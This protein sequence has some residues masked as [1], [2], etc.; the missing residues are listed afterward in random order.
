MPWTQLEK[1]IQRSSLK[2]FEVFSS[3]KVGVRFYDTE[4]FTFEFREW[5]ILLNCFLLIVT[6]LL[7]YLLASCRVPWRE[8][9]Y[10]IG[11]NWN[12]KRQLV[13]W[14]LVTCF[15]TICNWMLWFYTWYI[16]WV[17]PKSR[18]FDSWLLPQ[19]CKTFES[20]L[21]S[22]SLTIWSCENLVMLSVACG[23]RTTSLHFL[24]I[25]NVWVAEVA[26]RTHAGTT[27]IS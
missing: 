22:E 6:L 4:L 7:L 26:A 19:P 14:F 13:R 27:S 2:I 8:Y 18:H 23:T 17:G 3:P 12:C 10:I 15:L 20:C 16:T 11:R 5:K 25:E 24:N 9:T 21:E 1:P